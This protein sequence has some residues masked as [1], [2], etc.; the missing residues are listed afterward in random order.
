[1][2][3]RL[4]L[5]LRYVFWPTAIFACGFKRGRFVMIDGDLLHTEFSTS[6]FGIRSA[7]RLDE[8][9]WH[10]L[11]D[12]GSPRRNGGHGFLRTNDM[13]SSPLYDTNV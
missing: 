12:W 1:M 5:G 3:L 8:I 4:R 13:T 6:T 2:R 9:V 11:A 10:D 7:I